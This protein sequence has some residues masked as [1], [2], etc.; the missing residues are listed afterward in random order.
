MNKKGIYLIYLNKN[1]N[2]NKSKD[3]KSNK[4]TQTEHYITFIYGCISL[5]SLFCLLVY[6]APSPLPPRTVLPHLIS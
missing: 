5:H 1:K 4:I 6:D 3:E 2:K